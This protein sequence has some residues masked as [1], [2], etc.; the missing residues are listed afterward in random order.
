MFP[1]APLFAGLAGV[2]AA[3]LQFA[4]AL[5]TTPALAGLPFDLTL[6]SGLALCGLLPLLLAG[7]GWRFGRALALPL[8]G[9][10]GLWLWWV[11]AACWSV[12]GSAATGK[13]VPIV[14]VGP[15]MLVAGLLVGAD[16]VARHAL[17]R[18]VICL[19]AFIG[20]AVAWGVANNA[21]VLGGAIGADPAR[22][23]VQYQ[24]AGLA[25]A[26]AAGLVATGLVVA[27]GPGLLLR[28]I[29]LLGL[30]A[31]VLIP[32]GRAAFLAMGGVVALMPALLLW[33][34]GTPGRAMLWLAALMLSALAG[35]GFVLTDPGRFDGIRTI[36]RIL[37]D[38]ADGPEERLAMWRAALR[39]VDGLGIGPG[40]FPQA[41]GFG[42]DPGMHPHN[43]A[44]EAL[45][46]AGLPGLVLWLL[47]FGGAALV[48]L[49][50]LP[51]VAPERA[52]AIGTLVL[53]VAVT[54][55]VST[56]LS[57]RMAWFALGLALSL[58]VERR[59]V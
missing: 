48:A 14:L 47:A 6:V 51:R 57:N 44:L 13:L 1:T 27:R 19:G 2:S 37:G 5:K 18:A 46:E 26:T 55:M 50:R 12:N 29:L 52:V 32:G 7:G 53:P 39:M 34:R 3:L 56:D 33:L 8:L 24:L 38:P 17:T 36:E 15:V 43:H 28:G 54:V 25:V 11:V 10:A 42:A 16:A 20:A 4:G 45:T 30:A 35:L 22:T 9:A 41:A 49:A 40:G 58:A 23:R 59:H 21:V 31:A